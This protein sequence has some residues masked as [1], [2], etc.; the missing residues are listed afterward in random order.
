VLHHLARHHG[1]ITTR[2]ARAFGLPLDSVLHLAR[3]GQLIRVHRGVYRH[4]AS[5][6]T[7]AQR[8]LAALLAVG[9]AGVLSHRT[10]LA[11]HGARNFVCDLIELTHRSTSLPLH[12]GL[13]VHRSRTL[14]EADVVT[15]DGLRIT[16]RA[17]TL[18]DCCGLVPTTLLVR[19]AQQWMAERL[20][21]PDDLDAA[22]APIGN[23]RD[24]GRFITAIERS[25]PGADSVAEASLGQILRRAG[26][27][28]DHH[29]V[30]T[31]Q[32]GFSFEL[33][34]AYPRHRLGLEMDGDGIH[35]RSEHAFD[36]DRFRRNEL[37]IAGW[38]ILNFTVRHLRRPASIVDQVGRA[39][40]LSS[41]RT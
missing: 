19:Q 2:T 25:I 6:V 4:A 26:M 37:E 12:D 11:R 17:R 13:V 23:R 41:N 21:R 15:I 16:T 39:L 9:P 5:P 29:V 27:P 1:L 33:D 7:D 32:R 30:V 35:L 8:L 31:T 18:A 3:T 14:R 10:A 38:R 40:A 28:P 36:D 24:I 22:A 20:L 34:W